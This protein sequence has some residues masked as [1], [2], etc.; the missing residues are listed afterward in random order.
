MVGYGGKLNRLEMQ[1][2]I[3]YL[4]TEDWVFCAHRLPLAVAA[5]EA[6]YDFAVVT[7]VSV[8]ADQIQRA[9]IRLIPYDLKR[10]SVNPFQAIALICR[11]VSIYKS[12]QTDL[13]HRAALAQPE[14]RGHL[15]EGLPLR[16]GSWTTFLEGRNQTE[17]MNQPS[18][19]ALPQH[20]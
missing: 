13:V 5:R 8:H 16:A 20:N 4:V 11:L 14:A 7:N 12:E 17:R 3:I 1:K 15:P 9:G 2:K 6:G 18:H 10:G 19:P